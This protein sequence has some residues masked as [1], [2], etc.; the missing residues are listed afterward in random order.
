MNRYALLLPHRLLRVV[1]LAL[2]LPIVA[3]V[4]LVSL[5]EATV[6]VAAKSAPLATTVT[7]V[8]ILSE[9]ALGAAVLGE[10][11]AGVDLE[12]TGAAQPGFLQVYYADGAGWVPAQYLALGPR[13]G[14][15]TA[16]ATTD[17]P[18]LDAPFPD[19]AVLATV[20]EG[21]SVLL[22]GAH[23][24]GFDAAA[25]EGVGGWVDERGLAR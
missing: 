19:A 8:E 25:H 21:D 23:L 16:V 24:D 12:L 22:T 6:P 1:S 18:L 13:P 7:P 4:V 9:P 14:I 15:D 17:L 11:G 10:I 2:R 20:P 3:F 5:H